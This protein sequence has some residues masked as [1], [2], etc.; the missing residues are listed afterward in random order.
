[1][2]KRFPLGFDYKTEIRSII[3]LLG[4]AIFMNIIL[5]INIYKHRNYLYYHGKLI[6]NR[7]M[8]DFSELSRGMQVGFLLLIIF[9]ISMIYAHYKY[10]YRGSK[11]IYTMK[12]INDPME[13]H[14]RCLSVPLMVIIV[15]ILLNY[16]FIKI[17]NK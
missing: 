5:A 1:M 10:H 4:F 6:P 14:I 17:L 16:N 3:T 13:L 2:K 15:S 11:S 7:F 8:S 12:R 9:S